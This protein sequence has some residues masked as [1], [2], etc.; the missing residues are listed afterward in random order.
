M[1]RTCETCHATYDDA[2]ETTF[3]SHPF[4]RSMEMEAQFNLG[5][6]LLGRKVRLAHLPTGTGK[7]CITLYHDGMVEIEGMAG[8]FAPHIFAIDDE[9]IAQCL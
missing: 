9:E 3:C 5:L 4:L 1:E 8:R 6:K 2:R 7:T